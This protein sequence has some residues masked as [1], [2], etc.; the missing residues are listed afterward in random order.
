MFYTLALIIVLYISC[1]IIFKT[2]PTFKKLRGFI[3]I[4]TV[5]VTAVFVLVWF[6][7]FHYSFWFVIYLILSIGLIGYLLYR[8]KKVEHKKEKAQETI[9]ILKDEEKILESEIESLESQ[10]KQK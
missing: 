6:E 2:N 8:L 9:K 3:D 10:K 7:A 1:S 5:F 4:V